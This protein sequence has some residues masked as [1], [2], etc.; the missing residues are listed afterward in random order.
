MHSM[1]VQY[2]HKFR[3]TCQVNIDNDNAITCQPKKLSSLCPYGVATLV[4]RQK[5]TILGLKHIETL[6]RVPSSDN[7]HGGGGGGNC[8]EK[9]KNKNIK[10]QA[11]LGQK[12]KINNC[13]LHFE[14][15]LMLMMFFL[16]LL[17]MFSYSME[18][19]GVYFFAYFILYV[20][21]RKNVK[22]D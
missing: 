4:T 2:T 21:R 17:Q 11:K 6:S 3:Q 9:K 12:I 8:K 15:K 14:S 5:S 20:L 16:Q 18:W 22:R 13:I 1:I 19:V 7:L 10:H